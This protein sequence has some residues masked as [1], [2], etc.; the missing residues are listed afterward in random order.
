M[1]TL[2][3]H[4]RDLR[5]ARTARPAMQALVREFEQKVREVDEEVYRGCGGEKTVGFV[6]L[7]ERR[8]RAVKALQE[9]HAE[10]SDWYQ[11]RDVIVEGDWQLVR[12]VQ[13]LAAERRK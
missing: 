13:R 4:Y 10:F 6:A 12:E 9:F 11:C 7:R 3:D 1:P 2:F 5:D 8:N